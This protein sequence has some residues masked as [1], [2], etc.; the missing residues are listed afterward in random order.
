MSDPWWIVLFVTDRV[1]N[2]DEA[3]EPGAW[4]LL[5]LVVYVADEEIQWIVY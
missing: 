4:Q 3:G 1:K 2:E 5:N